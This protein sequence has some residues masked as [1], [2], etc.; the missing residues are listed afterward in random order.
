MPIIEKF[1]VSPTYDLARRLFRKN[2]KPLESPY[3]DLSNREI[4]RIL[5]KAIEV[6]KRERSRLS[7]E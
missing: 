2:L 4:Q 1:R 6:A 5:D 7:V 3:E